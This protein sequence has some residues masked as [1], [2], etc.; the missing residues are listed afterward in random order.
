MRRARRFLGA[1]AGAAFVAFV[2]AQPSVPELVGRWQYI[3]PPD[4]EGEVLDISFS[5]GAYRGIMNGLERAGE[6]G[7]FYYVAELT[8]L[9]V[10]A[11][12]EIGFTVGARS[13]HRMRPP[14]SGTA[15]VGSSGH[16]V[17][18]M[19]FHGRIEGA[20]LVLKCQPADVCPDSTL[21]FERMP[22]LQT[23]ARP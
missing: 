23:P 16:T 5:G 9:S 8:E 2:A 21:R 6:H 22:D 3:Q 4:A 19:R 15:T 12:G 18:R 1:V 11:N 10:A 13:F 20:D 14:L 17:D 7:L